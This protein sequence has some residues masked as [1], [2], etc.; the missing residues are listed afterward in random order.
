MKIQDYSIT[1]ATEQ[2]C[3]AAVLRGRR[4]IRAWRRARDRAR[5]AARPV[6]TRDAPRERLP[7]PGPAKERTG[8]VHT[9]QRIARRGPA[10]G[11]EARQNIIVT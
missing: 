8:R 7:F 10:A 3:A 5:D 11:P 9:G 1:F 2:K 4:L 6:A